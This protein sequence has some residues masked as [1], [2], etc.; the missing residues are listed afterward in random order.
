VCQRIVEQFRTQTTKHDFI[1]DFRKTSRL[2]WRRR[3]PGAGIINLIANAIK[4]SPEGGEI[5][6]TVQVRPE[7]VTFA[8]AIRVQVWRP[9]I[10]HIFDRFYHA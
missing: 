4:Y 3:S 1:I 10:Y 7:Q 8:L 9:K 6:V 2:S 5:Q